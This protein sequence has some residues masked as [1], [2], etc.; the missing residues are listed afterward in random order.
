[1]CP[2]LAPYRLKNTAGIM[3]ALDIK[4]TVNLN[5]LKSQL[6]TSLKISPVF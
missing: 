6:G 5:K 2:D 4:Q 1:M 3:C